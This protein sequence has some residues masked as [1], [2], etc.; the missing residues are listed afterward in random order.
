V[1]EEVQLLRSD[2]EVPSRNAGE[3]ADELFHQPLESLAVLQWGHALA[4]MRVSRF[5]R[6]SPYNS[7]LSAAD[8]KWLDLPVVRPI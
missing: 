4:P 8:C 6:F 7:A 3:M 1:I 2:C 5:A